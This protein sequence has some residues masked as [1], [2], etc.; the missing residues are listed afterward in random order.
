MQ[1]RFEPGVGR[2]NELDYDE[3]GNVKYV[4]GPYWLK[5]RKEWLEKLLHI[6]KG[7]RDEGR[8]I[9]LITRDELRVIR[10]E[11]INDPNEP[12]VN[13]SLPEIYNKI[14][15]DDDIAWQKNDLGFFDDEGIEAISK[16]AHSNNVSSDLLKKVINLEIEGSGLGNRRGVTNKLESIL[17][18]DWG[19]MEEALDRR[20]QANN[21][22]LEFKEKRDKFQSMLE[23][24]RS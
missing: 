8:S 21:E 6:E 23:E 19:S 3:E 9:E 1:T 18:Q 12:D 13:D 17:K 14:Y 20:I 15:P 2:T 16:V 11:W 4:P 22:V 5:I 7:I 10:Q 24:C